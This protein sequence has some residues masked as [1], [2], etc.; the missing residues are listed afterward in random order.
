MNEDI[1]INN[2][3]YD[4]EQKERILD[5]CFQDVDLTRRVFLKQIEDIENK[6]HLKTD[7]DYKR[8]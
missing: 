5:Y 4:S 7:E 8:N 6:N 3:T 1:I 2:T